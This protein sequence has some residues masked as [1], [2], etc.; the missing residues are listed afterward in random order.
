MTEPDPVATDAPVRGVRTWLD[1]H[2][3]RDSRTRVYL[4]F[5]QALASVLAVGGLLGLIWQINETN[6]TARRA[7]Y[8]ETIDAIA[9]LTKVDLEHPGLT[10][11]LYPGV[12]SDYARLSQLSQVAVQYLILGTNIHERSWREHQAGL[13]EDEDWR[14]QDLWFRDW[15]VRAG[16]FPA[17]W[18]ADRVYH[19][20]D[21]VRYADE[22]VAHEIDARATATAAAG[23]TPSVQTLADF[24][25]AD[26]TPT[27]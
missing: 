19:P 9:E 11:A 20:A 15:I 7:T 26:G 13:L 6:Q 2:A 3:H 27:C 17:I 23:G 21:F 5:V 25:A 12:D 14:A 24:A 22:L 10:C 16:M 4:E 8:N 18:E 1:R